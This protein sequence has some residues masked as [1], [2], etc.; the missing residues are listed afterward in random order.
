MPWS[1]GFTGRAVE[2]RGRWERAPPRARGTALLS[3]VRVL[4]KTMHAGRSLLPEELGLYRAPG[5]LG[6]WG[7]VAVVRVRGPD[8]EACFHQCLFAN[9]L[10]CGG[11]S[12]PFRRVEAVQAQDGQGEDGGPGRGGKDGP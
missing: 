10:D 6:F 12:L 4:K 3:L 8:V 9:Q 2:G 1:L 11:P 7:R 5:L